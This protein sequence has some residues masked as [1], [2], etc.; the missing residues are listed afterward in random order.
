VGLPL[1]AM[2]FGVKVPH[3]PAGRHVKFAPAFFV[4]LVTTVAM[5][6]VPLAS[7]AVGGGYSL[8]NATLKP[9]RSETL[10]L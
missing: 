8:L 4:S 5:P 6:A 1:L 2:G 7:S 3:C 9:R 10:K